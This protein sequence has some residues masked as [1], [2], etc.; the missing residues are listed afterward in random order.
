VID[1]SASTIERSPWPERVDCSIA[2][3]GGAVAS[4]SASRISEHRERRLTLTFDDRII[5]IDLLRQEVSSTG[6]LG[7]PGVRYF[8]GDALAAQLEHFADLV[9][10]RIDADAERSSIGV[11]HRIADEIASAVE[12][13]L[14]RRRGVA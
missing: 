11:A 8:S 13:S 10:G 3:E 9:E 7:T 12:P 1:A 4:L 2:F 6:V 5:E 14:A